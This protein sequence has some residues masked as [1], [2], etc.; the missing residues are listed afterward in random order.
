VLVVT[1]CV[2]R[3]L[4]QVLGSYAS[5][6]E[7]QQLLQKIQTKD[8]SVQDFSVQD[9]L[10]RRNG[11]VWIGSDPELRRLILHLYTTVQWEGILGS[12]LHTN[13]CTVTLIGRG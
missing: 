9:G 2:P 12:V 3:W 7:I 10:I 11:R 1:V 13:V 4:D 6:V 5:D 8:P